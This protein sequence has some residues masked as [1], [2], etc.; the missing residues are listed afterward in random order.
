[1]K[2]KISGKNEERG[3]GWITPEGLEDVRDTNIFF[4]ASALEGMVFAEVALGTAVEFETEPSD[5]GPRAVHV[6]RASEAAAV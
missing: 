3:F 6:K 4:H 1:M 2:G 5:R